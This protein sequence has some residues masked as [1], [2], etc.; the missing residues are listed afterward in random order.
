MQRATPLSRLRLALLLVGILVLASVLAGCVTGG[1]DGSSDPERETLTFGDG[2]GLGAVEPLIPLT[3]DPDADAA[4]I[5]AACQNETDLINCGLEHLTLVLGAV[6]SGYAFDVLDAMSRA[7]TKIQ[8]GDHPMAHYLGAHA[9]HIYGTIGETLATCSMKVFQG[10]YHGALQEYFGYIDDLDAD[11]V[12]GICPQDG[13]R[14][15]RYACEH[16]L[17]HGLVLGTDY[18]LSL[19]LDLCAT[20]TGASRGNC[21]GGAFMENVVAYMD[22]E[23]GRGHAHADHIEFWIDK[24]D[25]HYPCNAVASTYQ[26]HCWQMQTSLILFLNKADFEEVAEICTDLADDLQRS[27]FRSMG[28][29]ASAY[30]QRDPRG[31]SV[32]CAQAPTNETRAWCIHGYVS[33]VVS[34]FADPSAALPSCLGIPDGDKASCYEGLGRAGR[35][36]A[37]PE[38]LAAV[39]AQAEEGYEADCRSGAR[40]D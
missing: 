10:C 36:M 24:Y 12:A 31:V 32:K 13:T 38:E 21:Y 3:D 20:L 1:D 28:R 34:N 39:C 6:G 26:S 9:L 14:F 29:D 37:T 30:S 17:G 11:A 23:R 4:A 7:N 33:D 25:L 8:R 19:A 16:G 5:L 22:D 18:N 35:S 27:C 40:L 15:D 2:A